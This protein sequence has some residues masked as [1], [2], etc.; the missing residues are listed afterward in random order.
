M[1]GIVVHS[2]DDLP[3]DALPSAV[4]IGK[5]DGVHRGHQ[6]VI[7]Q[8]LTEARADGENLRTV[9]I[10]F[11]RHPA[12]LFA[13]ETAPT[14][15]LSVAQKTEALLEL[16][17]DLVVVVPFTSEFA[18]QSPE[19]FV[20]HVLV[21]GLSARRVLVGTDFRYGSRGAGDVPALRQAGE[22]SGFV[23][24]LV[25]DVCEQDGSRVSSTGIR[26]LLDAGRLDEATA[27]LGR[28]H[29]IRSLVVHGYAR[30]RT[31]GY[32]TANLAAA[33]EGY[34]PADGVYACWL[35][36]DG[37]RYGAAVSIGNNPTFGDVPEKTVEAHAIDVHLDL[38]DRT[39]E[40]EFAAY[41]R[42]MQKF[43][44]A[45]ALAHQMGLDELRIREILNL[46]HAP[47]TSPE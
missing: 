7:E 9:V 20:D 34:I 35:L 43:P 27:A 1:T 29:R 42:P 24:S 25:D 15:L 19:Q 31:L 2:L 30:G 21:E 39:V 44:S 17:V 16:G 40:L 14:P 11:D 32:P 45:D 4:T 18:A 46:P 23:V 3:K 13:P 47:T 41:V 33:A 38:Y 26:S 8:L 37:E 6:A 22:S 12:A 36:V 5:F 10:T 28:A